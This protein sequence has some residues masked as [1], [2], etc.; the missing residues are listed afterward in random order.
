MV[1]VSRS[2]ARNV[3]NTPQPAT[4]RRRF[5]A[6]WVLARKEIRLLLRDRMAAGLLLGMPLLFILV[7]GLLLGEGFG[8]KPDDTLRISL[9]DLDQ[10][11]GLHGR[12]WSSWVLQ[13]LK[14]TPG[15]RIEIIPTRAEAVQLVRE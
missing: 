11:E 8:Q 2:T 3:N 15:I 7:L 10:G 13:D 12:T 5:M 9:V 6:F 14:E 4:R 1:Y